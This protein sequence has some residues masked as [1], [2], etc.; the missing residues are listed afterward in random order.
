ME[1]TGVIGIAGCNEEDVEGMGSSK[2]S[3][4][5]IKGLG[6]QLMAAIISHK[7]YYRRTIALRVSRPTVK[8]TINIHI[9]R[10]RHAGEEIINRSTG[11]F[12]RADNARCQG[13]C[14]MRNG[15]STEKQPIPPENEVIGELR[16]D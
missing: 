15:L 5:H 9:G 2:D 4:K 16:A 11:R 3:D 10:A 12:P 1:F 6:L 13:K 8:L 14:C 7:I